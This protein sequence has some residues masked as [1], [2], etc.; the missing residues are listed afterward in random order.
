MTYL[1][2]FLQSNFIEIPFYCVAHALIE[3]RPENFKWIRLARSACTT[4]FANLI[5]HPIVFFGFL[6]SGSTTG[7]TWLQ[8]ILAAEIFAV[9][10]EAFL[11]RASFSRAFTTRQ[12]LIVT[13]GA[14]IANLA[15]WELGPWLSYYTFLR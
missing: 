10:A 1:L 5:T 15:S 2:T 3:R 11:H 12:W 14:V 6:G 8:G 7:L 13:C 4:T 9:V